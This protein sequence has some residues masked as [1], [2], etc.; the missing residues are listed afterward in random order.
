MK[1]LVQVVPYYN[2]PHVGGMEIRAR[3]R[4]ERLTKCGWSVETLT[5][6]VQ[7]YPHTVTDSDS[8]VH[9]LK[10]WEIAHTPIIFALAAALWRIPTD[11]VVQVETAIAYAPEVAAL[12]CRMRGI[13]YIARVPLDSAGHS[14]FR[15][16][17]L[18]MYQR[19][20]LRWVF[21]GA[22]AVIVLTDDDV[23]LI[24]E[25]YDVDSSLIKTIPNATDFAPL[26]HPRPSV[27]DP[28][29]LIFVGRVAR[30]KNLPLLLRSIR[31]FIDHFGWPLHL[32]LVGDGEDMPVVR[33]MIAKLNLANEVSLKGY[34]RGK[35]LEL[36]YEQADVFVMTS[37][38]ESF[39]Q[40]LLETM[41]KGLPVVASDIHGVR[42][43]VRDGVTGLLV[44]A[45]EPGFACALHR[46]IAEPGLYHELSSGSLRES[47]RYSWEATMK[48]YMNL[49][50]EILG[51]QWTVAKVGGDSP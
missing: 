6:S 20:V 9:Y 35:D 28:L 27:H 29:R 40:V 38:S 47:S 43:V 32:D 41:A 48:A 34:V 46:L 49:Y 5:S 1:H 15:G 26:G 17:I 11:S 24:S 33:N 8:I 16:A 13:P 10:S 30:Q 12:A 21:K 31:Y 14:R 3:E 18:S 19:R 23:K 7:T 45:N 4:A 22:A 51:Q 2:P 25:K 37:S 42:T 50:N 36:L 39:P 44:N